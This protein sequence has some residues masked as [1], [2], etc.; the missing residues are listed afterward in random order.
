[1][2]GFRW[3]FWRDGAWPTD[4]SFRFSWQCDNPIPIFCPILPHRY[5][6][7]VIR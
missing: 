6:L 7:A 5:I 2:N 3:N 1:M 4:Q